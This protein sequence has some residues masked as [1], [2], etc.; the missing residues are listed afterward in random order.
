M[1]E[2][3]PHHFLCSLGFEG[4]GYSDEFVQNYVQITRR[5]RAPDGSGNS[6]PIRVVPGTDT[7]CKPCPNRQGD[8]CVTQTKI[9]KLDEGHSAVLGLKPGQE[10]TWLEGKKLIHEKM[11]DA[12][13]DQACAPCS[14]KSLG[15]CA[16]ALKKLRSTPLITVWLSLAVLLNT[17][18]QAGA[19]RG[20]DVIQAELTQ[21][22]PTKSAKTLKNAYQ[23]LKEKKFAASIQFIS[24]LKDSQF[25]DYKNWIL[26][27]AYLGKAQ[28]ELLNKVFPE[29]IKS[30]QKSVE[31]SLRIVASSPYSPMLKSVP[32]DI[33]L[34]E[35]LQGDAL[36]LSKKRAP[37]LSAFERGF[38]R[39]SLSNALNLVRP[40]T[41]L[42][43]AEACAQKP[44]E[45]CSAWIGRF[46]SIY[47]RQ[48]QEMRAVLKA[49]P[50]AANRPKPALYTQ[51]TQSYK[52]P[53]L[54][55][56]AF[57]AQM[58]LFLEGKYG[59]AVKGLRQ[60]VDE[61]PK[62]SYRFRARYWLAEALT[63]EQDAEKVRKSY[64]DLHHDSPLSYYGLLAGF[65]SKQNMD[66]P[67]SATEPLAVERDP[68]LL[69]QE[70][71]RITR[72]EEL[73]SADAKD[74]AAMELKDFKARHALSSP[75]LMYLAAINERAGNYSTAFS[76]LG[77]L[78]QRGYE[79]SLSGAFLNL[80]FPLAHFELI[81]KYAE[82]N[83]LDPI[84]ILSL[85]K[86]ES[87]FDSTAG[88]SVGAT[89]LMQLMPATA[90]DT[91][92]SVERADLLDPDTNIRV[93]TQY[94]KQLL[95]RFNGNLALALAGYNA[96]PNAAD[97]WYKENGQKRS[98]AEFIE[99]IPY[100]ETREYV[101]AIVRNYYWYS[102]KLNPE[103]PTK[104]LT[105][106]WGLQGPAPSP[107]PTST[108]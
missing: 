48:S 20:L 47:P 67:I 57:D 1:L 96:G 65:A 62:S 84:L 54:D 73:L 94:L 46:A 49:F 41:L 58:V 29:A 12:A 37:A 74:L 5:L 83:A 103:E 18:A 24:R 4:N 68:L 72:A 17:D 76:I 81:R 98:L 82:V 7:V 107:T 95:T 33:G 16:A 89:G 53:D 6:I 30:A 15:L 80:V 77:D 25:V 13:F 26:A 28:S 44:G 31:N 40:D 56:T 102:R 8:L 93:G 9:Q 64:E 85:I 59:A 70:S 32:R 36:S 14:W 19:P 106:F 97:R 51:Q 21:R 22:T 87:A 108:P 10:L 27:Q 101:A 50:E 91:D 55:Q 2:F 39:L 42:H 105:F 38:Q 71:L 92:D 79:G 45:F 23:T 35:L 52:A 104:P 3:R 88:S 99:T 63:H 34:A 100:K 69:P 11:T 90:T 78:I 60:F 75:F 61:F 86:Q 43:Y 66:S